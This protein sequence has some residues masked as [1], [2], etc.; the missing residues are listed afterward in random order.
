MRVLF[1][2]AQEA[3]F[4][5]QLLFDKNILLQTVFDQEFKEG[6][7]F[8]DYGDFIDNYMLLDNE[9]YESVLIPLPLED[10]DDEEVIV[11]DDPKPSVDVDEIVNKIIDGLLFRLGKDWC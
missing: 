11:H 1:N 6:Q 9:G 3:N 7:I 10:V 5:T 8:V 4:F 2:D